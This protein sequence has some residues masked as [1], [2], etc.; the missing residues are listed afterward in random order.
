MTAVG[1]H[2]LLR[3][4]ARLRRAERELPDNRDL[5]IVRGS[6]EQELGG[7]VSIRLAASV[8][9]VS[10]TSLRRWIARGE[11][12]CVLTPAGRHE[13]PVGVVLDLADALESIEAGGHRIESV[14]ARQRKQAKL[15]RVSAR[16]GD[17]HDRAA[18]R[19][20]AYHQAIAGRLNRELVDSARHRLWIWE[21][22]GTIDPSYGE[23]WDQILS[24]PVDRIRKV[25]VADSDEG[26]D[27][28]Q[29]SPFAGELSEPE[30]RE[31]LRQVG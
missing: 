26:R 4:I 23:R 3:N 27:L 24:L 22:R 21:D 20:L 25:M 8:L 14:I 16:R 10:H 17:G 31:V 11:L 6:L 28:R 19:G 1:N 12:P 2:N 5:P 30:R 7:T 18:A 9:R 15:I 13:I 29:N